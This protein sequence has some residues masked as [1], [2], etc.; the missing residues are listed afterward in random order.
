MPAK[1]KISFVFFLLPP[2]ICGLIGLPK[3]TSF[4]FTLVALGVE[5]GNGV[6]A[7]RNGI[8]RTFS[9]AL[10]D[11]SDSLA[12]LAAG[13]AKALRRGEQSASDHADVVART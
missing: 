4:Q 6:S 8:E 13:H 3:Q 12:Q 11:F 1:L 7:V 9:L 5:Y 2:K 10:Y